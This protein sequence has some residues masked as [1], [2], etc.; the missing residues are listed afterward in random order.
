MGAKK[1][2]ELGWDGCSAVR[3]WKMEDLFPNAVEE[4]LHLFS[5]EIL[6]W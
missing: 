3:L 5:L 6:C 1:L 4:Q 2:V